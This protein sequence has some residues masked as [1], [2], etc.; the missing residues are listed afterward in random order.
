MKTNKIWI[1]LLACILA[2]G[3]FFRLWRLNDR[4]MHTDE[5]VH[6]EKFG[7]LLE[8]G[9]YAYDPNEFHGPTLNYL[10]LIS[11]RLRGETTYQQINETTLRIVPAVF[12]IGLILTP[13]FFI[14]G[15]NRRA[16]FFSCFL[17][18]FSPAF[19][20]YSR[21]YIQEMLLIFF[22]AAFLSCGWKYVDSQK[23]I[24]I[25]L[26][27]TSVGLM[28]ATKETF[29]F[30]VFAAVSALTLCVLCD[31]SGKQK[32]YSHLLAAIAAMALTSALFYSSYGTNPKGILDSVATYGI[33]LQRAGGQSAHVHPWYYYLNLLT[34]LEF[35]EP[36]T[37]NE[38]AIV[39]LA[40]IG[41]FF[42]FTRRTIFV[43]KTCSDSISCNLHVHPDSHLLPD[44]V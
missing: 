19:I 7:A 32:K 31:K 37:W 14:K 3:A 24:W 29:I 12:G 30:S 34:W 13:L 16:V 10:T 18:A 6:A 1:L 25:V 33:W 4:P 9:F 23:L 36:I 20:Y 15:I 38:D 8:K 35:I 5:A 43:G 28:H 11:A 2:S 26:S 40:V 42:A 44:S 21:Y 41:S 39:V 17:I 27:S 22:T